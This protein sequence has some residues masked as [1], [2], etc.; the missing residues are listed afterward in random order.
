M[1]HDDVLQTARLQVRPFEPDDAAALVALF[2]D[3]LVARWVD[4][5]EP[6][7]R[8][9]AELWIE[10]SR[11]NLARYGYGTGAVVERASGE[12]IGWAGFARPEDGPEQIIYGLA[13]AHWRRGYGR[14]LVAALAAY[15]RD[16]LG[17][18]RVVATVHPANTVSA[19]ILAGAGFRRGDDLAE[20]PESHCYVLHLTRS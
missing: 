18:D 20:D 4:A 16:A 10:R 15:A 11:E 9:E 3:P 14:E 12:M 5:G 1:I 17:R 8:A 7:P 2:A 13:R 19:H 6:L